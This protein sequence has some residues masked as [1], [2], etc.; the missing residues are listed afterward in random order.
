M[1]VFSAVNE[2][3]R[4]YV[5]GLRDLPSK[6]AED[7]L[8]VFKELLSD[9]SDMYVVDEDHPNPAGMEILAAILKMMSDAAGTEKKW[10]RLLEVYIN[11]VL[12]LM[13]QAEKLLD[14]N[15]MVPVRR[16]DEFFCALH[17]LVHFTESAVSAQI[18]WERL[19]YDDGKAPL[20]NAACARAGE[21]S[22]SR[23][24]Q[25]VCKSF[26]RGGDEKNGCFTE[27]MTYAKPI[28]QQE[29][30]RSTNPFTKFLGSR[31]C[32]LGRN[33]V[34]AYVLRNVIRDFLKN[35]P[36][37]NQLLRCVLFDVNQVGTVAQ[38]RSLGICS[39]L[40]WIPFWKAMEDKDVDWAILNVFIKQLVDF[41]DANSDNPKEL[42]EGNSPFDEQYI[43]RDI[44]LERL[45]EADEDTDDLTATIMGVQ[46][47][48]FAIFL[49][50]KFADHLPGGKYAN[51]TSEDCRG[52]PTTNKRPE[53]YF[54]MW[55][56]EVG[57]VRF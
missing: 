52:V 44:W 29:F 40:I 1:Q 37:N 4:E 39:K 34:Y 2:K 26:S 31:F 22:G 30:G 48:A 56:R 33:A 23:F 7:T 5:M 12:P 25:A 15:A 28:L 18:E 38:T 47:K 41:I 49:R 51:L 3:G 16:L 24:V 19:H 53:S 55:D 45:L 46:V 42:L 54:A 10:H 43:D 20:L 9:I 14:D 11:K 57:D 32:I 35:R 36:G 17:A 13:K 8:D 50:R 6:C 27:F 21:S